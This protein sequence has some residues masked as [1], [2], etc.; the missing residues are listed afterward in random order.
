[1]VTAHCLPPP[2]AHGSASAND[3]CGGV[4]PKKRPLVAPIIWL[5]P[6]GARRTVERSDLQGWVITGDG[7]EDASRLWWG[8]SWGEYELQWEIISRPDPLFIFPSAL[9]NSSDVPKNVGDSPKVEMVA[10]RSSP[11]RGDSDAS[12]NVD[13]GCTIPWRLHGRNHPP[14]PSWTLL[15]LPGS[16]HEA[17]LAMRAWVYCGGN[18]P[19]LSLCSLCWLSRWGWGRRRW[20]H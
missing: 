13:E 6:I 19:L 5:L 11:V 16:V 20:N 8:R 3:T 2:T 12:V 17:R 1:M 4:P 15:L 14:T 18:P 10:I 9:H 7:V